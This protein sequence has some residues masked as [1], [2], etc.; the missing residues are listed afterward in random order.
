MEQMWNNPSQTLSGAMVAS[1]TETKTATILASK[2]QKAETIKNW[3]LYK[4]VYIQ[5]DNNNNKWMDRMDRTDILNGFQN[6]AK[7]VLS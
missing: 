7:K 2:R 6:T 3:I 4:N 5:N 1:S